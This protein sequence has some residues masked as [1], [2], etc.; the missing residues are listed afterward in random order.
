MSNSLLVV[1]L[2]LPPLIVVMALGIASIRRQMITFNRILR[3][4]LDYP[5]ADEKEIIDLLV[6]NPLYPHEIASVFL[7][8]FFI[9]VAL[10]TDGGQAT[11]FLGFTYLFSIIY[12]ALKRYSGFQLDSKIGAVEHLLFQYEQE[13]EEVLHARLCRAMITTN[14]MD[15]KSLAL[16]RMDAWGSPHCLVLLKEVMGDPAPIVRELAGRYSRSLREMMGR[17]QPDSWLGFVELNENYIYWRRITAEMIG[18]K[19]PKMLQRLVE[20]EVAPAPLRN[21]YK[22]NWKI[23]RE[24]FQAY[25]QYDFRR[26]VE[27]EHGG[28]SFLQCPDC[29][30]VSNLVSPVRKVVGQIGGPKAWYLKDGVLKLQLWDMKDKTARVVE[31]DE[32]ELLPL[33]KADWPLVAVLESFANYRLDRQ[34]KV[35]LT[36]GIE[37]LPNTREI[38]RRFVDDTSIGR[39]P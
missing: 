19:P 24:G 21:F 2:L 22:G 8:V 18:E 23:H 25:C 10:F 20:L 39:L 37:L 11:V 1:L 14:R 9:V 17:V 15:Y 34:P 35:T 36:P 12:L 3:I 33:D 27:V 13:G 5:G 6:G 4:K 31:V 38:L 16:H 26:P 32:I 28:I 29:G 7:V 30:K